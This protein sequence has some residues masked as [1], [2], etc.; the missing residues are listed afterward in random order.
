[1]VPIEAKTE[2]S[3]TGSRLPGSRRE[4]V[5]GPL[6]VGA[7]SYLDHP[8]VP[9]CLLL[10]LASLSLF[11]IS[12]YLLFFTFLHLLLFS[13]SPS[14]A[15]LFIF[16]RGACRAH[17]LAAATFILGPCIKPIRS[18]ESFHANSFENAFFVVRWSDALVPNS[19][20]RQNRDAST[21]R[22]QHIREDRSFFDL[23]TWQKETG[24]RETRSILSA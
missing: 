2:T 15:D 12:F 5:P 14:L 7:L 18:E 1:M 16:S 17:A 4:R 13:T 22:K 21:G 3:L 24:R 10:I 11:L 19:F 6:A 9:V 20:P 8:W 23:S